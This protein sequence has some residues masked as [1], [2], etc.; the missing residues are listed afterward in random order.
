MAG[1]SAGAAWCTAFLRIF[2]AFLGLALADLATV[3][4]SAAAG[5]V[6]VLVS[7]AVA[8]AVVLSAKH[9][10]ANPNNAA[11]R[12]DVFYIMSPFILC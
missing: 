6:S 2:L 10:D 5:A 12:I 3:A 4:T 8:V 11:S 7:V 1:A 9:T